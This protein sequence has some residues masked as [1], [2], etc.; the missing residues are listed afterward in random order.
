M[1]KLFDREND[2]RY[3]IP[4]GEYTLACIPDPEKEGEYLLL[5]DSGVQKCPELWPKGAMKGRLIPT[6]FK[7]QYV[8]SWTAA[9]GK[10]LED[11]AYAELRDDNQLL[12]LVFPLH[13]ATLRFSR[14][15]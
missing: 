7:M 13:H 3:A 14:C 9:D 1:W 11:E 15:R 10:P 4:G 6:P 2:S 12:T 5:I 8:L